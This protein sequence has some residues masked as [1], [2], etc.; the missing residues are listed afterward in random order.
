[1]ARVRKLQ[2]KLNNSSFL[3]R[4]CNSKMQYVPLVPW[5]TAHSKVVVLL[6]L[7]NLLMLI[8]LV[9]GVLCLVLV[10]LHFFES[11]LVLLSS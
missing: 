2:S 11:F 3:I 1:M 4:F 6:L 9:C 10:L 5:S 7:I 8:P